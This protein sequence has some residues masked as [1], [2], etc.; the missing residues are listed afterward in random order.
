MMRRANIYSRELRLFVSSAL[1]F[2][3]FLFGELR[4]RV[5]VGGVKIKEVFEPL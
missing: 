3:R 2:A 5:C 1:G 4:E